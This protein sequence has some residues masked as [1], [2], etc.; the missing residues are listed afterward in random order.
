MI[1]A[2]DVGGTKVNLGLFD[3]GSGK[4]RLIR[5]GTRPSG[6]FARLQDL[7]G[8]FLSSGK[9]EKI[10]RA[11]FGIAGPVRNGVVQVTNLPWK[12]DAA[13]AAA[14]LKLGAVTIINDLEANAYGLAQLNSS[15][16]HPLNKGE[17]DATGN[18]ALISAGTGLGEA[19]LYWDGQSHRPF[20]SEGVTR[21]LHRSHHWMPNCLNT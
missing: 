20:A 13:E 4:L 19:G 9:Q 12:I 2:A 14:E 5:E 6:E 11:C 17:Q 1:L 10:E 3:S 15:E 18:A 8:D 16:L 7:V 21:I